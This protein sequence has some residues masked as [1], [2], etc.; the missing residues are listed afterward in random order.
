MP[1]NL[2]LHA[3]ARFKEE[4]SRILQLANHWIKAQGG[5]TPIYSV[6]L[7]S[8]SV[9]MKVKGQISKKRMVKS[10]TYFCLDK[11]QSRILAKPQSELFVVHR[12]RRV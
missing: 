4:E 10:Q 8:S 11:G 2:A 12:I 3:T 7:S 6:L 5:G 9:K 1:L